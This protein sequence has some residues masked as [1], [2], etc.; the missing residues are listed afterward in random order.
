[1]N[2]RAAV[3]LGLV[4]P[5]CGSMLPQ[6]K[7]SPDY[8]ESLDAFPTKLFDQVLAA[9]VKDGK[10]DYPGLKRDS[11]ALRRFTATVAEVG[12]NERS[13]LFPSAN[14]RF[15]YLINAYNALAMLNALERTPELRSLEDSLSSFFYF[16]SVIVDG[17]ET[18]LYNLENS[19]IRP[20]MRDVYLAAGQGSRLGRIHFALNCASE[21]CPRL[22]STAFFP[23]T[24]DE[25]LDRETRKF[26]GE[27]RDVAVDHPSRTVRISRIY[28]W[29]DDDFLDDDGKQI[30]ALRWI[31]RYRAEDEQLDESYSV[32]FLEYDWTLN[33]QVES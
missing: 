18:S 30:P 33:R 24:L 23:D 26:V 8:L 22:P 13:E 6:G 3:L 11:S 9:R 21:S 4:L 5:R 16:T 32:E 29:H 12:P 1:M 20:A 10:V 14:H 31:N 17:D 27:P 25:A 15:A 28:D 2:I 7:V 19:V